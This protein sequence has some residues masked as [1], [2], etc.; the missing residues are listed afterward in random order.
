MNVD[1]AEDVLTHK[2]LLQLALDP[3]NRPV[4]EIR[5]V[6]VKRKSAFNYMNHFTNCITSTA[7]S[8]FLISSF[9]FLFLVM[10]RF[11]HDI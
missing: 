2:R 3:A 6:Q 4:F 11:K 5:S 8:S 7:S 1:R 10:T 9:Y